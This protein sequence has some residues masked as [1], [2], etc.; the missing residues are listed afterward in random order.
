MIDPSIESARSRAL[1]VLE[2]RLSDSVG[3]Q[4]SDEQPADCDDM[5][6]L[7]TLST[8]TYVHTIQNKELVKP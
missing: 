3:I 8:I 6:Y 1:T 4:P 7:D 5:L 2:S